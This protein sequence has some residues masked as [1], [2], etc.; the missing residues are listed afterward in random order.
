M[1]TR[2]K[3]D[4]RGR[5]RR[6]APSEAS[7]GVGAG[8]DAQRSRAPRGAW[9]G[10]RRGQRRRVPGGGARG[11]PSPLPPPPLW[12]MSPPALR[13]ARVPSAPQRQVLRDRARSPACRSRTRDRSNLWSPRCASTHAVR[14]ISAAQLHPT[15]ASGSASIANCIPGPSE[16]AAWMRSADAF[17][18]A[19]A[20]RRRS[21]TAGR[22]ER[23]QCQ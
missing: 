5:P 6:R 19:P 2:R 1:A 8:A 15:D 14:S 9:G 10:W 11:P 21:R 23:A 4:E 17:A 20:G 7:C 18:R 3:A 22:F 12:L 13:W 16:P